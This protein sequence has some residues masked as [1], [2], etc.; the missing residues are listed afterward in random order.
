MRL[1]YFVEEAFSDLHSNIT[2]NLE[3]YEKDEDWLE[4]YFKGHK[5]KEESTID[6]S[7]PSLYPFQK[8]LNDEDKTK[9]DIA[10]VR[11]VY[12]N[13]KDLSPLQASNKYMW[14]CLAHTTYRKYVIH[15]WLDDDKFSS[16]DEKTKAGRIRRVF[17]VSEGK[18][19]LEANAIARLW[20]YGFMSYDAGTPSNPYH[21]T[22][23]LVANTKFCRDFMQ[24]PCCENRTVGKGVLLAIEDFK[25]TLGSNEGISGYYRHLKK[26]LNRYGAVTSLDALD[27]NEVRKLS[28]DYLCKMKKIEI[29]EEDDIEDDIDL[30]YELEDEMELASIT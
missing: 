19:S 22:E 13:L 3:L 11:I 23:K 10:N 20:W 1:S 9:E 27:E 15:R 17:F 26:Y 16:Y 5:Y 12:D 30:E 18:R 2:K 21:L 25:Q 24:T 28:F 29:I 6:F 14:T 7:P 8:R 4:S